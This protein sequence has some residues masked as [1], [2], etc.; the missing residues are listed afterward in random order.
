MTLEE[1]IDYL[2]KYIALENA[3][4]GD[5]IQVEFS[6]DPELS[7]IQTRIPTMILQPFVENAFIHAFPSRI[8][9]PKFEISFFKVDDS[10]YRCTISDNGIG[11]A[12]LDKKKRH[13]SK[14]THLIEERLSFLGYDPSKALQVNHT[15]K[16]TT[17]TLHLEQ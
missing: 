9:N 17:V 11:S 5:R 6:I 12:S 10:T 16:G 13:I 14:G 3:R 4:F 15:A 7:Q 2:Q 8:T 1:E